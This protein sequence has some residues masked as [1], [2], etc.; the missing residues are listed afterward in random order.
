MYL[1][2]Y[3]RYIAKVSYPAL[4]IGVKFLIKV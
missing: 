4:D 3:L 2:Q 1:Y